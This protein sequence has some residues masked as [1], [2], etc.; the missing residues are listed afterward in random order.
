[1]SGLTFQTV[2]PL[3]T[4]TA[5][6]TIAP[7]AAR[8]ALAASAEPA[9]TKA[10][11]NSIASAFPERPTVAQRLYGPTRQTHNA[12]QVGTRLDLSA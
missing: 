11:Q 8:P 9:L 3:S 1:M 2:F 7:R 5:R 4:P 6:P 12:P 10:E